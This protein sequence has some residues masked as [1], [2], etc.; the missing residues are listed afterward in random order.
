[1]KLLA[2]L[3][4]CIAAGAAF[5]LAAVIEREIPQWANVIRQAGIKAGD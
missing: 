1:M 2:A 4:L 5:E 3:S